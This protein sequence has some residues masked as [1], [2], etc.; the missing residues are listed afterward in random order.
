MHAVITTAY[1][2]VTTLRYTVVITDTVVVT[3]DMHDVISSRHASNVQRY[4]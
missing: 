2:N 1:R 4:P 3:A